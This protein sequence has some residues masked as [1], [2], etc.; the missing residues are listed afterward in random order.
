MNKDD[1]VILKE[2]IG[3][4]EINSVGFIK[5]VL[6]KNTYNVFFIGKCQDVSVDKT[7]VEY[8]D[9]TK[10][11]KP[12]SHK[13]CNVC[14]ILKDYYE[15]FAIN[16][17]DAK[18]R[19]TTRPTCKECRADIDG[20]SIKKK[21]SERLDKIK[22]KKYF[23]CPICK[24]GSIPGVTANLVKDHDHETGNAREWICDSCNTGLGRF[25][26]DIA[27]LKK[28]IKYFEKYS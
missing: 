4:I 25:K 5:E 27:L 15:D 3:T 16:Q 7:K 17:T 13:I 8:L 26:D 23:I 11:G 22:P 2:K 1:F 28:A 14:H 20:K 18:G 12:Y 6:N 10:T 24:K 9:T 19:K 21:E